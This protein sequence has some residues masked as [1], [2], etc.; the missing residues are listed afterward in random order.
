M[1]VEI[2]IGPSG[3]FMLVVFSHLSKQTMWLNFIVVNNGHTRL[4]PISIF[5]FATSDE[6]DEF[7]SWLWMN[8]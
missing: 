7:I 6:L 2:T 4:F 5:D 1:S 8:R 3:V